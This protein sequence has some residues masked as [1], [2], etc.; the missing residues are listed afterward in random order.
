LNYQPR[1]TS[2]QA[3]YE[4]VNWLIDHRVIDTPA[5]AY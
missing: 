1:Y 4:A 5:L 2:L 3:V